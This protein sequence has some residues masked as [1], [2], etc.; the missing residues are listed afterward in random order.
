MSENQLLSSLK[1]SIADYVDKSDTN[2]LNLAISDATHEQPSPK[3][4]SSKQPYI[5]EN[6]RHLEI[7][8]WHRPANWSVRYLVKYTRPEFPDRSTHALIEKHSMPKELLSD[9]QEV[10]DLNVAHPAN[11]G[12]G[13]IRINQ[14]RRVLDIA[15]CSD[16]GPNCTSSFAYSRFSYVTK[17]SVFDDFF[18]LLEWKDEEGAM[19][20]T[21]EF[22]EL[23]V[24]LMDN[25]HDCM[26]RLMQWATEAERRHEELLKKN[27]QGCFDQMTALGWQYR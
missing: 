23:L 27:P 8:G 21:W 10:E 22:A 6:G 24:S 2:S 17:H 25:E 15:W 1:K 7:V 14:I 16:N 11:Q 26:F 20:M 13:R 19:R 3:Q 12:A 9:F 18:V 4:P 5:D